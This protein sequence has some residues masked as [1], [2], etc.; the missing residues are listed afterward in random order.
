MLGI[1]ALELFSL[2]LESKLRSI[3]DDA[4]HGYIGQIPH[5]AYESLN[6]NDVDSPIAVH[7]FTHLMW[8]EGNSTF[9]N[10]VV[11]FAKPLQELVEIV[12]KMI[13]QTLGVEKHYDSL[14]SSITYALRISEYGVPLNQETKIALDPHRDPNLLTVVCQHKIGGLEV[15][16]TDGDWIIVQPSPNSVTVMVGLGF[17]AWSNMRVRAP[18]H[19]V[20]VLANERRF[21]AFYGSRP[22]HNSI[23]KGPKE[24]GDDEYHPLLYKPFN[25]TDFVS[26][27][28][29]ESQRNGERSRIRSLL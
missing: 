25:Y 21:S 3:S 15:Q 9:S 10:T 16:T 12:Q 4:Y 2:P 17:Q 11:A 27:I 22:S 7:D 19:R 8:P 18:R 5:L 13:L 14:A 29:S 28:Y 6:I 26:F 1:A 24:L 23:V 20:K